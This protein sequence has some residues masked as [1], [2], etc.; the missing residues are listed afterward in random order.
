MDKDYEKRQKELQCAASW[1]ITKC[2]NSRLQS[3]MGS[4]LQS[5]TKCITKS[6]GLKNVIVHLPSVKIY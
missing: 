6:S 1:W 5:A 2:D 3:A 4:G